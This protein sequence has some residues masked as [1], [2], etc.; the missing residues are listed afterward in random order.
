VDHAGWW[1]TANDNRKE[2][3]MAFNSE[4]LTREAVEAT[5]KTLGMRTTGIAQIWETLTNPDAFKVMDCPTFTG[6]VRDYDLGQYA[7]P[8]TV[9]PTLAKL[10]HDEGTKVREIAKLL[11]C[12]TGTVSTD[13]DLPKPQRKPRAA[14]PPTTP[15]KLP[16]TYTAA[17]LTP[18]SKKVLSA[19][20]KM[21]E[22]HVAGLVDELS[23]VLNR[24]NARL[25]ELK[26]GP[27]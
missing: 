26:A 2:N 25:A 14:K 19:L 9:R 4:P 15:V 6:F 23:Y 24:M 10:M 27:A 18:G 11:G 21:D 20:P 16:T 8:R 12:S 17:K 3:G 22:E 5:L 7:I 13:L 1:S